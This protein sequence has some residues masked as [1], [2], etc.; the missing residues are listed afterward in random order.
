MKF[1]LLLFFVFGCAQVTGLNM[2]KHQF[3]RQPTKI[4]WFQV[5]GL[6]HE[7]LAMLRFGFPTSADKTTLESSVCFGQAWSFNLY[8]LRPTPHQSMLTQIT[9]KKDV[10]GTCDDWR[11]KPLWS[12]LGANSYRSGILEIDARNDESLLGAKA[13]GEKGQNYLD[14]SILWTMRAENPLGAEGYLPAVAQDF[15][16]GKV[17]WDKTCNAQGCGTALRASLASIY[18]QF[19]KNSSRH[20]LLVRDFSL[21]HALERQNL[22]AAREVLRE[23]DKTAEAF[24]QLAEGSDDILVLVTGAGAVDVDFPAEG[25]EWQTFDLKGAGALP[26]R[27]ELMSPVF[28]QGARAENFC[29]MYEESQIFERLL[30]GPKQQGLELKIINPFN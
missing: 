28:A 19:S 5:A 26:R 1:F 13:C 7:Q 16:P 8:H 12:Y 11:L 25:K 24:Y 9:G 21:K 14:E 2:R 3:G 10:A 20:L 15:R 18:R 4:I 17:Y 29:G 6:D 27:G 22:I 23:I 30:S